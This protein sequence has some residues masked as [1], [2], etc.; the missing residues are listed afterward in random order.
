MYVRTTVV[1]L[2]STLSVAHCQTQTAALLWANPTPGP[3]FL[4]AVQKDPEN[5]SRA[6][7]GMLKHA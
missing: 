6:Q 1:C 4:P 2:I 7:T 3:L 5:E